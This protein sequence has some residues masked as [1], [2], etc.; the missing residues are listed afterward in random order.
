VVG[1][2]GTSPP[3]L[4]WINDENTLQKHLESHKPGATIV[5]VIISTDKT[6]VTQFRNKAAYPVY[7]TIGNIP[8]SIR[9]KPSKGAQILLGYLPTTK[10]EHILNKAARR[11]A[12]NNL[13]HSCMRRILEPLETAGLDG[14]MMST[15]AGVR[16]RTHPILACFSGEHAEQFNPGIALIQFLR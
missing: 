4:S 6:Q 1:G 8:K 9:R 3:A 5:P 13:F 14:V 12:L 16:H 11:R 15:G 7:L 10:L 2:T